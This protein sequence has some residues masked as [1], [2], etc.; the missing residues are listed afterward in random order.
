MQRRPTTRKSAA[1]RRLAQL[2]PALSNFAATLS[3]DD[4]YDED[5][6]EAS[7]SFSTV[8]GLMPSEMA[9]RA[10][11]GSGG[12]SGRASGGWGGGAPHQTDDESYIALEADDATI[13]TR[14]AALPRPSSNQTLQRKRKA[15]A[16]L[17]AEAELARTT[18]KSATAPRAYRTIDDDG[19]SAPATPDR[20]L[21]GATGG[22]GGTA[23]H[24]RRRF[25]EEQRRTPLQQARRAAQE[26]AVEAPL[27]PQYV[28]WIRRQ[29]DLRKKLSD[30]PWYQQAQMVAAYAGMSIDELVYIPSLQAARTSDQPLVIVPQRYEALMEPSPF[31][32]ESVVPESVRR[33]VPGATTTPAQHQADIDAAL[34]AMLDE[35]EREET[36]R[37]SMSADS[38]DG[39]TAPEEAT[40][41][42]PRVVNRRA[43]QQPDGPRM[44]R[45]N[46]LPALPRNIFF[47][48]T[49]A[50]PLFTALHH[51]A[52]SGAS[53][54]Y[55]AHL[56]ALRQELLELIGDTPNSDA[57][58]RGL[59][60][61]I[62]QRNRMMNLL[63]SVE[64]RQ[65]RAAAAEAA[66]N[67]AFLEPKHVR[68][69]QL[70]RDMIRLRFPRR[71]GTA[72]VDQ[73]ERSETCASLFALVVSSLASRGMFV[74][75][76][77]QLRG[78]DYKRYE[79]GV[80]YAMS[81]LRWAG[82]NRQSDTVEIDMNALSSHH[83][84]AAARNPWCT[85][86]NRYGSSSSA[87]GGW[88]GG[89]PLGFGAA[90]KRGLLSSPGFG[91][92]TGA[93]AARS[94]YGK[95]NVFI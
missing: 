80:G 10:T 26:G 30:Q 45:A 82:I 38:E 49:T 92:L 75:G 77:R 23:P 86:S 61:R 15:K 37:N 70:A 3:D 8:R 50:R 60:R 47:T 72:T 43:P 31:N 21:R 24:W 95:R 29:F 18:K 83:D 42:R 66:P 94:A 28:G 19:G 55:V 27:A 17:A 52:R 88:G 41:A 44:R 74:G 46:S 34:L 32:Y 64:K 56:E 13:E 39:V 22:V 51:A 48:E 59:V 40:P 4:D 93:D 84:D 81:Q 1:A 16:V 69:Q 36:E 25:V 35:I 12:F 87:T 63:A 78:G 65:E 90:L 91:P 73:F 14:T 68:N 89:A 76:R 54:E 2:S 33:N 85:R 67:V 5:E 53:P 58:A 7:M 11:S 62:Y 20:V 57:A 6:D 9:L 71:L 79:D